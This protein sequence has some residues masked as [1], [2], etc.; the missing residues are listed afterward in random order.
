MSNFLKRIPGQVH[1]SLDEMVK[2]VEVLLII[3]V[4]IYIGLKI[5][6][7]IPY[8]IAA[9]LGFLLLLTLL[10]NLGFEIEKY[11]KEKFF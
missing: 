1:D 9:Y 11:K 5:N 8:I 3:G 2:F 7:S 4:L 10:R 6:N